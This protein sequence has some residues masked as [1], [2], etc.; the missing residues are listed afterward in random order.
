MKPYFIGLGAQK[1]GTSWIYANLDVHPEIHIPV[2]EIHFFSR[3]S[4]F[5]K[6]R[7][8]YEKF[9][10]G[11]GKD[12][13]S[14][15][16]CTSYLYS[17]KAAERIYSF[18]PEIKLIAV[19]RNP[20]DRAFSN[21]KNDLMAGAVKKGVEFGGAIEAHPEYLEQGLYVDQ[22]E[23]YL[24]YFSLSNIC[25]LIYEDIKKDPGNFMRKI[26]RFLDVDHEFLSDLLF[27]NINPS[28]IPKN[29]ALE[30]SIARLSSKLKHL[31]L[32]HSV[33]FLRRTAFYRM[34]RGMN[35]ENTVPVLG[36]EERKELIPHFEESIKRLEKL[37]KREIPEWRI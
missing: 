28:Y 12:Q 27:K 18:L 37:I 34:I 10:D 21:F 4:R 14:G 16:F 8:W 11:C 29:Q 23:R 36:N 6:G 22:L 5:S 13:K 17:K 35:R 33:K 30:K 9:F 19:L 1:S 24:K 15:E 20:V 3:E 2:K 25:V 32:G 26:Y 7:I 31:K